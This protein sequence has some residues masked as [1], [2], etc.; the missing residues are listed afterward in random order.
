MSFLATVL[1]LIEKVAPLTNKDEAA[2]DFLVNS[3]L[4]GMNKRHLLSYGLLAMPVYATG[5]PFN[6]SPVYASGNLA[7]DIT[8]NAMAKGSGRA[9]FSPPNTPDGAGMKDMFLPHLP[10]NAPAE[11]ACRYRKTWRHGGCIPISNSIPEGE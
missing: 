4:G 5:V 8:A 10:Y 6:M 7:A 3:I 11:M 1:P 2:K 9:G